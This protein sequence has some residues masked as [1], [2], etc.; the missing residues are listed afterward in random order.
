M[1]ARGYGVAGAGATSASTR[2][3]SVGSGGSGIIDRKASLLLYYRGANGPK[4]RPESCY[5][6]DF[7]VLYQ[8]F[9][10][11]H[12]SQPAVKCEGAELNK[13][14]VECGSVDALSS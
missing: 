8:D 3:R 7:C 2:A 4:E 6:K 12:G 13:H 14:H 1:G 9:E 10:G 5:R 11:D